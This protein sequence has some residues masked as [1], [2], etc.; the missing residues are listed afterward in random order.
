MPCLQL[1]WM[2]MGKLEAKPAASAAS[3][4]AEG[5]GE[6]APAEGTAP[7]GHSTT[8]AAA[9]TLTNGAIEAVTEETAAELRKIIELQVRPPHAYMHAYL[10]TRST[11][12]TYSS[13]TFTYV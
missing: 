5:S 4:A 11:D 12:S 2:K 9:A 10:V 8:G 6:A 7:N 3:G 1:N 13:S